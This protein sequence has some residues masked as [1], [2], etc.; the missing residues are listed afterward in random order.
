MKIA[1]PYDQGRVNQHFGMSRE[2]VI[3]SIDDGKVCDSKV[4]G[5]A[6]LCHNH[7]G[8]A[9]L[10]KDEGVEVVIAGGIGGGM[11][12][13]LNALGFRIVTGASGD[14]AAVARD[15]ANGTLVTG[16]V[17]LCGCGCDH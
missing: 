7:D 6:D 4:I 17:E 16:D 13:A 10:L 12:Q 1:M 9:G 15:F 8:L 3:F 5:S 14:A 11:V 2:F